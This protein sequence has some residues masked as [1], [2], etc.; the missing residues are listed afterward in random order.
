MSSTGGVGPEQ[1]HGTLLV[2]KR[3]LCLRVKSERRNRVAEKV[4]AAR[5]FIC[6]DSHEIKKVLKKSEGAKSS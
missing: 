1:S 2:E 4:L 5:F 3:Y 6:G